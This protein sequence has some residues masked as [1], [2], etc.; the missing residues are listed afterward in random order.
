MKRKITNIAILF[1]L[2]V[3]PTALTRAQAPGVGDEA[4]TP[5]LPNPQLEFIGQE[6]YEVNNSKGT[7]YKLSVTNRASHPDFLWRPTQHLAPCGKNE[8]ASRAWV[9]IFGSPG[10]KRLA[11]FCALRASEDLGHLWFPVASGEKGPPCV[12][13]VMT[14]R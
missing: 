14:D 7:R 8:N 11:G 5:R 12:Y 4:A 6:T 10:D 2:I 3:L 13:I 1:V 9:E